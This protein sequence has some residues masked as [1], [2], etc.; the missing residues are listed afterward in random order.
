MLTTLQ[1]FLS[2]SHSVTSQW[3]WTSSKS[4]M[5]LKTVTWKRQVSETPFSA[6]LMVLSF[7]FGH[8][9]TGSGEETGSEGRRVRRQRSKVRRP[10]PRSM[11]T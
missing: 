8:L 5:N 4:P 3:R 2:P 1:D 11:M 10:Y 9:R 6:M 7:T